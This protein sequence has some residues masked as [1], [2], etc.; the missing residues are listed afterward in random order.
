MCGF[1]A[2]FTDS[3]IP[4]SNMN[5]GLNSMQR[6]GPD[7]EGIWFED[8]VYIGH[9]RLAI[10]DLNKRAAQPMHSICGKYTIAFNGEIYNYK[11]L[12]KILAS[13]GIKL[14]T[15]SDT[16]VIL[17]L[18]GIFKEDCLRH[19]KGMFSFVIWDH[20]EKQAFAARDPYGIKPLYIGLSNHGVILASQVKAI[21]ATKLISDDV[22]II[23]QFQFWTLGSINEPNTWYKN[24][25][26]LEA[27]H[28][29]WIKDNKVQT[30][31]NWCQISQY[32]KYEN[33]KDN[34][35]LT[36]IKNTVH[37]SIKNSV[38]RHLVA[39]VPIGIFLSGGIDSGTLASL[40]LELGAKNVQGIT[41]CYDE[42]D[43]QIKDE[44]PVAREIAK[45]L[46]INHYL[47]K[48]TKEEFFDDIPQIIESMDQP[49][50]D[51][52]NTWYASKAV[53][54]KNLK[55]VMSGV[56]GDELF[57]GYNS[58]NQLP[59]LVDI[60]S[61]LSKLPGAD[62]IANNIMQFLKWKS[63]NDRWTYAPELL[64]TIQGSWFLRR[65]INT[66]RSAKKI[67][68]DHDELTNYD[69]LSNLAI[70]DDLIFMDKK[71]ALGQLESTL[72][73]KN[74]LLRD[75]DWA[76]MHHSVELRTPL[77]DHQLLEEVSPFMPYLKKFPKKSLLS[78]AP[79]KPLPKNIL[80]RK[81][82]GFETPIKKW[83]EEL[84]VI[85]NNSWDQWMKT[86]VD[87][88]EKI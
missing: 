17:E 65:S 30:I 2:G 11:Y 24:I 59:L 78:S 39:D 14:K 83:I 74:Q 22:D 6:R 51:G 33:S 75:S 9:K 42:F 50:I 43:G 77:V 26:S 58:F 28:Y 23:G 31:K 84:Y 37:Q 19:L 79:L 18:F 55:V 63:S 7:D 86:I 29:C 34:F 41:I 49:S 68:G 15:N 64:K 80:N 8:N 53:A 61:S 1:I 54:E 62:F 13:Y 27:G 32:W 45:F 4:V 46:N 82:T 35:D 69:I 52:V 85:E 81:K 12:Q 71:L 72:Y 3:K 66:P 36:Y 5:Q 73:L 88:Y 44:A 67:I 21:T 20:R 48:V 76:S 38:K 70:H 56:G 16:E 25:K 57:Q 40:M 10:I 87:N 60:W 47:R